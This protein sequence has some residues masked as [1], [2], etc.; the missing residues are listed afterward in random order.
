[1]DPLVYHVLHLSA[2]FLL[3]AYTFQAFAAPDPAKKGRVM[4]MSG[5]MSLIMVVA[6]FGL[7]SKLQ[8][9]FEPWVWVKVGCWLVLSAVGGFAYRSKGAIPL[10][11]LIAI[12]AVVAAV[13]M[14]YARPV[15]G[16]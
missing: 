14:V 16:G 8:I 12:V 7:V 2:G 10:L 3:T 9:G 15:I 11:K 1:M 5:I 4:M 6:G 13:Y